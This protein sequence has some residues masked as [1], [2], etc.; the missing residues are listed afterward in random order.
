M[1]AE[2][3]K[4]SNRV[5]LESINSNEILN[6]NNENNENDGNSE[7]NKVKVLNLL[8]D[9]TPASFVSGIVTEFGI[10]PPSSVAVLL[11]EMNPQEIKK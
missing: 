1:C 3:Y 7:S 9:L 11:R 2:T 6:N 4:I 8:F 5:Q 10:V